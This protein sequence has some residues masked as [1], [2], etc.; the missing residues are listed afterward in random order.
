MPGPEGRQS[1]LCEWGLQESLIVS[2]RARRGAD[3]SI[4]SH[5]CV[6]EKIC[7]ICACKSTRRALLA[8]VRQNMLNLCVQ[9]HKKGVAG[10]CEAGYA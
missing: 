8:H 7:L 10:T 5:L 4:R 9:E 2:T 3:V 6:Q 1:C